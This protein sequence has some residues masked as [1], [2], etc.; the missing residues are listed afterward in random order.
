MV[1]TASGPKEKPMRPASPSRDRSIP[2][3]NRKK[4][5]CPP[6]APSEDLVPEMIIVDA[7]AHAAYEAAIVYGVPRDSSPAKRLALGRMN[8]LLKAC[9]SAAQTLLARASG[10]TLI[11][12]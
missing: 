10:V 2:R 11:E 12:D 4:G 5:A 3:Q 1:K 7:L 6:P 8:V 9:A